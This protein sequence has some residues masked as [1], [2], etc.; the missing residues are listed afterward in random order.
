M[1]YGER[2][3]SAFKMGVRPED[4]P[5]GGCK[6]C[7]RADPNWRAFTETVDDTVPLIYHG[8]QFLTGDDGHITG[9]SSSID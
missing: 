2:H 9:K 8:V 4:L 5:C 6:Y 1:L 3:C 7:V